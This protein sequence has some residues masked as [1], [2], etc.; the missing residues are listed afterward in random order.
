MG[1]SSGVGGG[2]KNHL[3]LA[4]ALFLGEGEQ[5]ISFLLGLVIQFKS[6]EVCVSVRV[7]LVSCVVRR[8]VRCG[9]GLTGIGV[10]ALLVPVTKGF[11]YPLRF[12]WLILRRAALRR[13]SPARFT[14]WFRYR[15][16]YT[17]VFEF[18]C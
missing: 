17:I 12:Y 14:F 7:R 13:C 10:S 4:A 18:L 8:Q 9:G 11:R 5:G 16:V 15:C 3:V 2:T 6:V 1:N